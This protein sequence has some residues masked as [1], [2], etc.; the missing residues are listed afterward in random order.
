[1]ET[2]LSCRSSISTAGLAALPADSARARQSLRVS[3]G[4]LQLC[5]E[6]AYNC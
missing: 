5:D 4:N 1:M 3:G 2:A 6:P